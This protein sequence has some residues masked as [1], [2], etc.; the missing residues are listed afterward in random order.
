MN[1]GGA[2]ANSIQA[3]LP[4]GFQVGSSSTVNLNAA[5]YFYIAIKASPNVIVGSYTGDGTDNRDISL[6]NPT[7]TP[8]FLIV[9]SRSGTIGVGG[10]ALSAGESAKAYLSLGYVGDYI[11]ASTV[12]NFQVGVSLNGNGQIYDYIAFSE[13]VGPETLARMD[14]SISAEIAS[15]DYVELKEIDSINSVT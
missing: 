5:V 3:L 4:D 2:G 13:R 9:K 12:N 8:A 7:F 11:Q 10:A 14:G 6:G 15:I 1:T